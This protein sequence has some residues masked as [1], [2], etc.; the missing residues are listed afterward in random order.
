M[1]VASETLVPDLRRHV[2]G[3]S[4]LEILALVAETYPRLADLIGFILA[5]DV[6]DLC[7]KVVAIQ[8]D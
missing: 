1:Q 7:E 8:R 5:A 4:A 3:R 6:V 2:A